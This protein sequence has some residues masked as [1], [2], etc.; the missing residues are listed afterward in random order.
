VVEMNP[1]GNSC[2]SMASN[3][4]VIGIRMHVYGYQRYRQL[5]FTY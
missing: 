4:L 3:F 2:D 1:I 5:L